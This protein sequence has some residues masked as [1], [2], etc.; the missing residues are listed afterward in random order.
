M[1]EVVLLFCCLL[2]KSYHMPK[3]SKRKSKTNKTGDRP[4]PVDTA[5]YEKIKKKV[6]KEIPKHSAYRSGIVVQRYKAAGGKYSGSRE[7]GALNR[8]FKEDWRNQRGGKGYKRRGDVYRPT[9]R[10]SSKTPKT[11]GELS[12]TEIKKAMQEKSSTGRVRSFDRR[13]RTSTPARRYTKAQCQ[14]MKRR[15]KKMTPAQKKLCT[16]TLRPYTTA[17]CQRMKR[18]KKKMTPTQKRRCAS[19]LAR[20]RR[21]SIQGGGQQEASPTWD[22]DRAA[23]IVKQNLQVLVNRN[24]LRGGG[25]ALHASKPAP[26][27]TVRLQKSTKSEKKWQVT[28]N[29]SKTV[30]FGQN[31]AEDFTMHKDEKRKQRYIDRH[32]KREDW[33]IR[34][35]KKAGFWSRWLLWN[36]P[37]IRASKSD[38]AKRFRVKFTA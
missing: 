28:I 29:G 3:S 2:N 4:V 21:R 1:V 8:W 32:K 20:P 33:T 18:R 11:F 6:Y 26:S 19:P 37:T 38:I 25:I 10:V 30:H 35:I 16:S 36:K 27:F 15:K 34:G 31:G 14:D 7:K 9:R 5:L 13:R 17:Q 22:P 23:A 12:K 24:H